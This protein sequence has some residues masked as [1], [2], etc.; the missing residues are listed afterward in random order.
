MF[1][2]LNFDLASI[3]LKKIKPSDRFRARLWD[4]RSEKNEKSNENNSR[5]SNLT[6][7]R[8]DWHITMDLFMILCPKQFV[9]IY[10][11]VLFELISEKKRQKFRRNHLVKLL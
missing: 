6:T 5:R 8:D 1:R 3:R 2:K 10:R 7:T 9:K 4:R 11:A